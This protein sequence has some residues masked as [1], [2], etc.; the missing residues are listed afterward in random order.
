[1]KTYRLPKSTKLCSTTAINRLFSNRASEVKTQS[2]LAYP[3]RVVW[4][5][6]LYRRDGHRGIKFLISVPK[7]R[8]RNAVDR[9]TMRRRI[10]ESYRLARR[11]GIDGCPNLDVIFI[12]VADMLTDSVQIR[13]SMDRLL[14]KITGLDSSG[15]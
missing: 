13:L 6:A 3:L 4:A 12:Y 14:T 7:K 15:K 8:L 1:M 5:P 11:D 9:V 10:R 2:A